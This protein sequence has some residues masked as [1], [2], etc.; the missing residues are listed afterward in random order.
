MFTRWR[1]KHLL[2][3]SLVLLVAG[4]GF[5]GDSDPTKPADERVPPT[6]TL[7]QQATIPPATPQAGV[8]D[9]GIYLQVTNVNADA[10]CAV[11]PDDRGLISYNEFKEAMPC[12]AQNY[13]IWPADRLID[14]EKYWATQ[15]DGSTSAL[16]AGFEYS[17]VSSIN[18]CSWFETWILARTTGNTSVEKGALEM[19]IY[20]VP[21]YPTKVPHFPN[22]VYDITV[23][24]GMREI[25]QKAQLGDPSI[26][27]EIVDTE[28]ATYAPF[29]TGKR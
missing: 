29:M 12:V 17:A 13:F 14:F 1:V 21:E 6:G 8:L 16:E 9:P 7:T 19:I 2:A 25:G 15:D 4:C 5:G 23:T 24:N 22:N 20:Y 27:Q 26:I 11:K 10:R 18:R 28:C 3:I